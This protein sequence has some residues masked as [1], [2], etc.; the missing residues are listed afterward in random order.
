MNKIEAKEIV[1]GSIVLHYGLD[2]FPGMKADISVEPVIPP[3]EVTGEPLEARMYGLLCKSDQ[4]DELYVCR[5]Y[6]VHL[7]GQWWVLDF[8]Y[9]VEELIEALKIHHG[10]YEW[11]RR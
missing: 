2:T 5:S 11:E 3:K 9:Q 7:D 8:W 1:E 6:L 4:N 10:W